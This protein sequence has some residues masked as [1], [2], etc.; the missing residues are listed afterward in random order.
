MYSSSPYMSLPQNLGGGCSEHREGHHALAWMCTWLAGACTYGHAC[1]PC[2]ACSRACNDTT[3]VAD[4]H[5][6]PGLCTLLQ[7]GVT[8]FTASSMTL[9]SGLRRPLDMSRPTVT[10]HICN[11]NLAYG[12]GN[13]RACIPHLQTR[14]LG[15]RTAH[16]QSM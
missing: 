10:Q 5:Q 4:L 2:N 6:F 15:N 3:V 16:I 8:V 12:S 13:F 9:G 14:A 11:Q 7:H 1:P